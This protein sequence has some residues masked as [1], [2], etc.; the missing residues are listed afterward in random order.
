MA[1]VQ[2]IYRPYVLH[3]LCSFEEEPPTVAQMQA[4]RAELVQA[5]YPF[6]VAL[7][8]GEVVGYCY[9]GPYRSRPAYRAT[10]ENSVYVAQGRHGCGIGRALL[11]ALVARCTQA[12]HAQMVAVVGNSA[13]AGSIG[14]HAAQG[15][16]LVG[17]LRQVGFKRGQWVDT[18]LM[19]R[20]LG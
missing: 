13:N 10:V 15:F 9:A 16:E 17:T 4:R 20:A 12:G 8:D 19:Q 18:V 11:Q 1:S 7:L 6:L 5:G 14:L 2:A 3:E